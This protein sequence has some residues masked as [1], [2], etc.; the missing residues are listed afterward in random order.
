MADEQRVADRA[1]AR[2]DSKY[3]MFRAWAV[4]G[5]LMAAI[6]LDGFYGFAVFLVL[7]IIVACVLGDVFEWLDEASD[8]RLRRHE[9]LP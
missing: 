7:G 5:W 8:E 1:T 9:E 4:I 6:L 2:A 3:R